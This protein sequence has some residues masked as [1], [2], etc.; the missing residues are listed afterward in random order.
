MNVATSKY[1]A[2]PA[3]QILGEAERYNTVNE[4]P[5]YTTNRNMPIIILIIILEKA[6]GAV[7]YAILMNTPRSL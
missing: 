7:V 2:L 3:S 6:V 1:T 4:N 5:R